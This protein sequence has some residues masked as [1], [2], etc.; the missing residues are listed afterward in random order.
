M[1]EIP[2]VSAGE[3][4]TVWGR[5]TVSNGGVFVDE[6]GDLVPS[7]DYVANSIASGGG[8]ALTGNISVSTSKF[9]ESI[10]L[11]IFNSAS[12][13]A[14]LTTL[15][16]TGT[17]YDNQN[18][19][20]IKNED[21]NSAST[22]QKRTYSIDG[23]FISDVNQANNFCN[24]IL[25]KYKVPHGEVQIEVVNKNDT[26]YEQILKR[27]ISDRITVV[28]D[29]MGLR[30]EFNIDYMEHEIDMGGLYHKATYKLTNYSYK[31]I[32]PNTTLKLN[33]YASSVSKGSLIAYDNFIYRAGD[34][35]ASGF[36]G[37]SFYDSA[38]RMTAQTITPT[39]QY[40]LV[41]VQLTLKGQGV[42][43]NAI[44][45]IRNTSSGIPTGADLCTATIVGTSIPTT[46]FTN[47]VASF[48]PIITLASGVEMAIV[49]RSPDSTATGFPISYGLAD[50]AST[51]HVFYDRGLP[52]QTNDN[53]V[54]WQMISPA[55]STPSEGR[56]TIDFWFSA[57][58][59]F[60][61]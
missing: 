38:S 32:V 29:T 47:I 42:P 30:G 61:P 26:L 8:T 2:S 17:W 22:Y 21:L 58:G 6:W 46:S 28:N 15:K 57:R 12:L 20:I 1:G 53:G 44:I 56:K 7:T 43:N 49:M 54:S 51:Y 59:Y 27:Q 55:D 48:S 34:G 41:N 10:K 33:T 18:Q 37:Y 16:A 50:Y 11:D 24:E 52:Y 40:N 3:T 35:T 60:R 45:G 5:A 25:T 14:Y 19:T 13:T 36:V 39:I 31:F 9:A 23:K 4:L